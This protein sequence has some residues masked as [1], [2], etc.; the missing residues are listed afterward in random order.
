LPGTTN[1]QAAS[2]ISHATTAAA[3]QSSRA[4]IKNPALTASTG[5]SAKTG[6]HRASANGVVPRTASSASTPRSGAA[7]GERLL[8]TAAPTSTV[9]ATTGAPRVRYTA[10]TRRVPRLTNDPD[11]AVAEGRIHRECI[12]PP[13]TACPCRTIPADTVVPGIAEDLGL[14]PAQVARQGGHP[15]VAE[16]QGGQ[17]V[18]FRR[19]YERFAGALSRFVCQRTDLGDTGKPGG[20]A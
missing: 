14:L 2:A 11:R 6:I 1:G 5:A 15:A 9:T 12:Q 3:G 19:A 20:L 17:V 7:S 16:D 18:G 4:N 8:T 10:A 13:A